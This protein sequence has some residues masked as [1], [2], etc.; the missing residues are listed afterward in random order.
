ML[1]FLISNL[2]SDG[3]RLYGEVLL[4][5]STVAEILILWFV[6]KDFGSARKELS[7][8]Y[9]ATAT[10]YSVTNDLQV[11]DRVHVQQ[12]QP[13]VPRDQWPFSTEIYVIRSVDKDKNRA[14]ATPVLPPLTY[15]IPT[16]EGPMRGPLSPFR[17]TSMAG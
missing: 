4:T 7:E 8:I 14:L 9:D 11:G 15:P 17:K 3:H 13:G 12:P 5:I 10:T 1:C 2:F 16:V 6:W